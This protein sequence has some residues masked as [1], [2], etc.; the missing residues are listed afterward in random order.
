M[1]ALDH[2]KAYLRAHFA[3]H[4]TEALMQHFE[5]AIEAKVEEAIEGV[6]KDIQALRDELTGGR[7]A[8]T[9]LSPEKAAAIEELPPIARPDAIVEAQ[10][11]NAQ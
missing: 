6:H 9:G 11:E 7:S 1:S 10:T 8:T 2:I 4:D 3:G 5:T